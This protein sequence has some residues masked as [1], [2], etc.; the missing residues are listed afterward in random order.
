MNEYHMNDSS[1][2]EILVAAEYPPK[3]YL[4]ALS[5]VNLS[6]DCSLSPE[7]PSIYKGLLLIGGGDILPAYYGGNI[8]SYN[9][10]FVKDKLEFDIAAYFIRKNLPILGICRGFQLI[11]VLLGGTLR[12]VSG[13]M[14]KGD[15]LHP[16][17]GK[18]EIFGD[19]ARVN[20]AHRQA[21][22]RFPPCMS[23]LSV[24]PDNV[25]EGAVFGDNVICAQ[26]HPERLSAFATDKIFGAFARLVREGSV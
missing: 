10:N 16:V 14:G 3:T 1:Y 15:I 20:S 22:E 12:C 17:S 5:R 18:G 13:H 23:V 25:I 2:P 26:F 6:F 24:S 19:L 4:N 11:N 8:P 21:L 7:N 9:V